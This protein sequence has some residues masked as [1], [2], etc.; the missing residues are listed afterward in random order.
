MS[1]PPRRPT[2]RSTFTPAQAIILLVI[3]VLSLSA[4]AV[5]VYGVLGWL[6]RPSASPPVS[7]AQ[8]AVLAAPTKGRP[9]APTTTSLPPSPTLHRTPVPTPT[10]QPPQPPASCAPQNTEIR[11]GT[12][13]EVINGDTLL[14]NLEGVEVQVGYAGIAA[15]S[16]DSGLPGTLA[17]QKNRD[18]IAGQAVVLVKDASETDLAGRLLRYVFFTSGATADRFANYELVRLGY[19]TALDSPDR[20]CAEVLR[21]AESDA[22]AERLGLWAPTPVPTATFLSTVVIDPGHQAPCN[23][24]IRYECSNFSSHSAAQ[25]CFNAC[26]DYNSRLD[27]DHDGLACE[28]LP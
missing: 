21:A 2:P 28:Q 7:E 26:N 27:E 1:Q 23:C 18:L 16:L 5:V 12:V 19:A 4:L 10:P 11:L 25:A 13:S 6:N 17:L 22:R 15:P 14:V 9:T 8:P 20:A 24:S 3:A